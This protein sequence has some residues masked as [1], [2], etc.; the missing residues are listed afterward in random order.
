MKAIGRVFKTAA[1]LIWLV[2]AIFVTVCLLSY[3]E[4]RVSTFGKYSLIIMDSDA[5]EPE[6]L[7]GDLLIVKRNSDA[8]IDIGDTVFYYNT[9]KD[10]NTTVFSGVVQNKETINV[11]E[12]TYTVND[13]K[14]SDDYIIGA[15]KSVKQFH[16]LGTILSILKSKWGYMFAVILPTLFATV[17]EAILIFD[18]TKAEKKNKVKTTVK[19]KEKEE[20]EEIEEL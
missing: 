5:Y 17:Y 12:T 18:L 19:A 7:E 9:A 14:I 4:F 8:K 1:I 2:V 6:Y 15:T 11:A 13:T 20:I 3:N 16:T 10:K